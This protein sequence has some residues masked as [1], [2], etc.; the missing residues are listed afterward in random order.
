MHPEDFRQRDELE[1]RL[2]K[3]RDEVQMFAVKKMML[4]SLLNLRFRGVTLK[5]EELL[6]AL[7]NSIIHKVST[8]PGNQTDQRIMDVALQA[9]YKGTGKG[10]WDGREKDQAGIYRSTQVA[11]VARMRIVE[12]RKEFTA[13]E[14]EV[15]E[16]APDN[17]EELQAW[18]LLEESEHE[19][20]Q[21]V[22]SRGEL[23]KAARASLLSVDNNQSS[24]HKT[25]VE[26]KDRWLKVRVATDSG[27]AG[28]VMIEGILP[29]VKFERNTAPKQ[30]LAAM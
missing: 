14:S 11:K 21:T 1:N 9:V 22:I 17:E 23:K 6:I 26:V 28:H 19:Q 3:I 18:C 12:E 4:E 2:G 16:E 13:E 29:R 20:R 24:S 10:I 8:V 7:E 27:A 30:F 15:N 25:K 5:Y